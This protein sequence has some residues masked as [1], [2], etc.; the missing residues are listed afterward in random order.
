MNDN[1]FYCKIC[2]FKSKRLS[3]LIQHVGYR[4]KVT[5]EQYYIKYGTTGKKSN[6][7]LIC[8]KDVKYVNFN[9]GY[10]NTCSKNVVLNLQVDNVCCNME[11][12]VI[13]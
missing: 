13:L 12:H 3:T 1:L 8:D 7:C 10:A 4:H 2:N 9:V 11:C 5:S 6:K